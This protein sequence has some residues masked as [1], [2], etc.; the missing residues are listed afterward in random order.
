MAHI[1]KLEPWSGYKY[2]HD[3]CSQDIKWI[4]FQDDDT[5]VAEKNFQELLV[6]SSNITTCLVNKHSREEVIR[7]DSRGR[8]QYQVV[9]FHEKL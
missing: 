8:S 3:S 2:V 9:F 7:A 4:L 5:V 1:L 6:S